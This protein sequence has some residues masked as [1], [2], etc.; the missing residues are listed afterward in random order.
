MEVLSIITNEP[1]SSTKQKLQELGLTVKEYPDLDLYLVKYTKDKCDMSNKDVQKCRG[2][3]AKMSTNELVCLP[4]IKSSEL[5]EVYNSI[6]QWDGLSMEDFLD[7]TMISMF[8]QN[9][10]WMISTRSN[11]GA[12]CKWVGD[13]QFSEMFKEAC[14]L[15]FDSLDVNKFY[16]FVLMHPENIIVTQYQVP[17][18]V[19]VSS[20]SVVD[21]VVVHHDIYKEPLEIKKP[22][23][24]K[25]NNVSEI[26]DFVRT[27]D[28]QHQGIVLKNKEN[29][30]V[31]FRNENYNYA[32]S[33]KG[34]STNVK[35]LYYENK[36]QKNIQEY[37]S[38]FPNETE[39]YNTFNSE[40]I[41]LV[42]D[43][44]SYY[45]KYHIKKEIKI[46]EIP[47]QL[48]PLCYDL[49]GFYMIRRTTL[50][51]DD[52]YNYLSSL[53]SAKLLFIL[54]PNTECD[55]SYKL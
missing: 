47:F 38:F 1:F 18:I 42:S 17:E 25:F 43:T 33:L 24:Y 54:K 37:L 27:M 20:G 41:Q 31:K 6:E 14:N 3:I 15:E 46:K 48:R 55:N 29:K 45:K 9:E 11:I 2:L 7:G 39:M 52:V 44:L 8:Y 35:F 32:K 16:T 30:R 10:T 49:H 13:K 12:N 23:Q 4:P 22:I 40:F 36:K 26:R 50:Q 5:E 53:D 19:L 51:F 21:G 28:F 34:N